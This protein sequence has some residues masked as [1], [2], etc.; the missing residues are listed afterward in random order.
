MIKPYT[1]KQASAGAAVIGTLGAGALSWVYQNLEATGVVWEMDD[2][3]MAMMGAA[4]LW[5]TNKLF[6][7]F[8][9]DDDDDTGHAEVRGG[10][11]E[12]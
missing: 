5:I 1:A 11:E 12:P 8:R 7:K 6:R 2:S 3:L 9:L 4:V 10:N